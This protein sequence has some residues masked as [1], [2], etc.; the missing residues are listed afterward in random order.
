MGIDEDEDEVYRQ[1]SLQHG[2]KDSVLNRRE[3]VL[4]PVDCISFK[5]VN[6]GILNVLAI[7]DH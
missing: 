4:V 5:I 3:K 1:K 7:N 2:K 6:G